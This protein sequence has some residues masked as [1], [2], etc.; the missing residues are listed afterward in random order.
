[1]YKTILVGAFIAG[2]AV[3][4]LASEGPIPAIMY[5]NPSCSC[6]ET[7][8]AYLE[9]NGFKVDIKPSNNLAQIASNMGVPDALQ[10]CHTVLIE[11][12]IVE[13]FVPAD[14]VHKMLAERPAITGLSLEGM[15][16]GSPGMDGQKMEPFTI[17]AFTLPE[18]P[19][20]VYAVE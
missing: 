1:M 2:I 16:M 14:I 18:T 15:P 8:A 6:C 19:P 10:G 7:Y 17:K 3:P 9:K 13:G 12:Y 11:G 4:A 5:K 20:T